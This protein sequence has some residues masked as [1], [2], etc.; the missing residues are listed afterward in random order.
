MKTHEKDIIDEIHERR[1]ELLA[2]HGNDLERF[3]AHLQ[4]REKEHPERVVSQVKVVHVD[5]NQ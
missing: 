1:A 2:Q 3:I 4:E 5:S